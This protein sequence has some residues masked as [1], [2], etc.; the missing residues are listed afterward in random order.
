MSWDTI[1]LGN[2]IAAYAGALVV[3]AV[4]MSVIIIFKQRILSPVKQLAQATWVKKLK[5]V[6]LVF[7]HL[8]TIPFSVYTILTWYVSV[9]HLS[10]D[11]SLAVFIDSVMLILLAYQIVRISNDLVAYVIKTFRFVGKKED[12][13]TVSMVILVI[14]IIVRVIAVLLILM[15]IG[16]EITPLL[17]SLGIW[18]IAVAFALKSIL[19]DVF[20]SFSVFLGKPFEIGDFVSIGTDS[21]TVM[22][23]GLQTTRIKTVQWQVLT[24]PNK[25]VQN[26][27][28]NNF[29]QM[30][31]RRVSVELQLSYENSLTQLK[32]IPLL[33][34]QIVES[35]AHVEFDRA[36]FRRYGER[37]LE[38]QLVYYIT[39]KD[40]QLYVDAQQ[41]I[42]F[43]IFEVFRQEAILFAYPTSIQYNK[44]PVSL[45]AE[46]TQ[47]SPK[48]QK[49]DLDRINPVLLA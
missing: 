28:I 40:F 2:T 10:F 15:N 16:I 19:E 3:R 13:T 25:E 20:A 4:L 35:V 43:K 48:K 21:G 33:L 42:N 6:R 38:Y 45:T 37:S 49:S 29:S 27:R 18:G 41:E 39:S 8:K 47:K 30:Q 46:P 22:N 17:A 26:T 32:K 14:Q 7:S 24:I 44:M 36:H 9:Q 11:H 12:K 5:L 1:V 34:Q 23:I 31:R